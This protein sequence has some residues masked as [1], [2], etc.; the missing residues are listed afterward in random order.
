MKDKRELAGDYEQTFWRGS[1]SDPVISGISPKH[2]GV[3][4]HFENA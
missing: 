4:I 2:H 1:G 3:S